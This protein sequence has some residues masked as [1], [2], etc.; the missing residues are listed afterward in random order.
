M[1]TQKQLD[2]ILDK[3]DEKLNEKEAEKPHAKRA[4][5][6][7]EHMKSF[8]MTCPITAPD[9]QPYTSAYYEVIKSLTGELCR[10]FSERNWKIIDGISRRT[11][12]LFCE[13]PRYQQLGAMLCPRLS[14]GNT[15]R[16]VLL[17]A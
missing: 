14:H 15:I 12:A 11:L 10:R 3:S 4:R 9:E 17:E 6:I 1:R 2:K 7:P 13:F 8:I 16:E 5:H